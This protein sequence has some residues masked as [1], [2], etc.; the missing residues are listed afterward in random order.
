MWLNRYPAQN[1]F[2]FGGSK[3]SG[4][5]TTQNNGVPA[6][7]TTT[8][9]APGTT[10]PGTTTAPATPAISELDAGLNNL[11]D[12]WKAPAAAAAAATGDNAPK[13]AYADFTDDALSK[14]FGAARISTTIKPEILSSLFDGNQE[15]AA[16]LSGILDQ[17]FQIGLS[18]SAKNAMKLAEHGI[19]HGFDKFKTGEL[20]Q[21]LAQRSVQSGVL[22]ANPMFAHPAYKPV[23]DA[24]VSSLTAQ[25]PNATQQEITQHATKHITNLVNGLAPQNK[26]NTNTGNL[27]PAGTTDSFGDDFFN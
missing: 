1:F 6:P 4:G 2:N 22:E 7:G 25:Y 19:T 18:M 12:L 20:S 15:K 21:L 8:A 14:A 11:A 5:G 24:M 3:S 27:K 16:A 10:A 23:Y 9:A 26:T 17:A 13:G